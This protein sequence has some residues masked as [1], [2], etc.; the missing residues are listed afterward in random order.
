MFLAPGFQASV[1]AVFVRVDAGSS[2]DAGLDDGPDRRL[3]D[4]GQHPHGHLPTALEQAQ[5]R[6]LLLRQRAASWRTPQPPA[7][8]GAPLVWGAPCQ[9]GSASDAL[10]LDVP[11]TG[12][13]PVAGE[14]PPNL[15][16]GRL[17]SSRTLIPHPARSSA[18]VDGTHLF[19]GGS[20]QRGI[21]HAPILEHRE[22]S[23]PRPDLVA[24]A[25]IRAPS[26]TV[27]LAR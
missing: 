11:R 24:H 20:T 22:A 6:R 12:P 4:I 25:R 2:G 7:S 15:V 23:L 17:T 27:P 19:D 14:G 18:Q 13:L 10:A 8:P 1:D 9:G 3:P 16:S 5:D 26:G 21:G